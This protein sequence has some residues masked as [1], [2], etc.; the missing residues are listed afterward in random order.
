MLEVTQE[1]ASQGS[2]NSSKS[3]SKARP[4]ACFWILTFIATCNVSARL[5]DSSH[6]DFVIVGAESAGSVLANRLTEIPHWD[7]LLVEAGGEPPDW[8]LVPAYWRFAELPEGGISWDYRSVPSSEAC[9]GNGCICRG[10]KCLGGSSSTNAMFYLRGSRGYYD[11]LERT[12]N[13][14]WGYEDV[15]PYFIKSE[16]N[17]D[18]HLASTRYH[19]SNGLLN[20]ENFRHQDDNTLAIFQAVK[21]LG[22]PETDIN[23]EHL[24]G[25]MMVQMTNHNGQRRNTNS[26]FLKTAKTRPNLHI[27]SNSHVSKILFHKKN[28]AYGIEY[29]ISSNAHRAFAS[30]EIIISAGTIGSLI[31]STT[32]N[33]QDLPVGLTFQYHPAVHAVVYKPRNSY[34]IPDTREVY[35]DLLKYLQSREGPLTTLG[36]FQL[37]AYFP[38]ESSTTDDEDSDLEI[39]FQSFFINGRIA[40]LYQINSTD[41]LEQPLIQP[42]FLQKEADVQ[43]LLRSVNYSLELL[44][45]TTLQ[46]LGFEADKTPLRGC[47]D[48]MWGTE[49]YWRYPKAVVNPLLQV[50]GIDNLRVI[51]ASILPFPISG[52]TNAAAI[53]IGEKGAD[54]IKYKWA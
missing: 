3:P 45:T 27:L 52:H 15:L 35:A 39:A 36:T 7:V 37:S 49:V 22:L 1:I 14:G 23:G 53:M 13:K 47:E 12:G 50:N 32:F 28:E 34:N 43:V 42:N 54:M 11:Q 4:S 6:D 2:G 48:H 46:N 18:P 33:F 21:E 31:N 10:G 19:G 20:V 5:G 44:N 8:S 24:V 38:S 16:R 26:A 9:G 25:V 17:G 30:K 41:P 51:D 29:L 40:R